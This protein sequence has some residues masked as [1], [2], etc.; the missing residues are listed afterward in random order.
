M[1]DL[2]WYA[3][4]IIWVTILDVLLVAEALGTK[5]LDRHHLLI[6]ATL[7]TVTVF[8]VTT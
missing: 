4:L 3:W 6:T 1:S 8:V 7:L 5:T 2:N